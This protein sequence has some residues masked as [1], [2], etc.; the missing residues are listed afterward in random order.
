MCMFHVSFQSLSNL[1]FSN[2]ILTISIF[3][4]IFF[5]YKILSQ[6]LTSNLPWVFFVYLESMYSKYDNIF[7][8]L[9]KKKKKKEKRKKQRERE[10]RKTRQRK[11]AGCESRISK[12][13][14]GERFRET[15]M[16]SASCSLLSV[17]QDHACWHILSLETLAATLSCSQ[18]YVC[19]VYSPSYVRYLVRTVIFVHLASSWPAFDNFLTEVDRVVLG[20]S[21]LETW[22]TTLQILL[23]CCE[24]TSTDIFL[25]FFF[26]K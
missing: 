10:K 8:A 9:K 11:I 6:N 4:I 1:I 3:C 26:F 20:R 19:T 21:S 13:P 16:T 18:S 5:F 23:F 17:G 7:L 15:K 2:Y 24:F 12:L 14:R 25:F 22:T